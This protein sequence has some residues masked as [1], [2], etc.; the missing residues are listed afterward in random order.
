MHNMHIHTKSFYY[1]CMHTRVE[2]VVCELVYD[3]STSS[4]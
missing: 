3:S 2:Y 4:Y 1:Y